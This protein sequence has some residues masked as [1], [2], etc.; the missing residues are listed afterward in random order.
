[1]NV[2]T[3]RGIEK[4]I[5]TSTGSSFRVSG[6]GFRGVIVVLCLLLP[7]FLRHETNME[8]QKGLLKL[9]TYSNF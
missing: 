2:G 5:E 6:L 3:Y 9:V 4:N 1:M 8:S 7:W